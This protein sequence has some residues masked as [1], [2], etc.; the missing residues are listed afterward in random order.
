MKRVLGVVSLLFIFS[1]T[2]FANVDVIGEASIMVVP[3]QVRITVGVD[4]RAKTLPLARQK[5]DKK[6]A[7]I[8]KVLRDNGV[9]REDVQMDHITVNPIYMDYESLILK[10]YT[11]QKNVIFCVKKVD[12][13]E[14]IMSSVLEAGA[15]SVG[16]IQFETTKLDALQIKARKQAILAAKDRAAYLANELGLQIGRAMHIS[17]TSSKQ[18]GSDLL[19]EYAA[20]AKSVTAT[21]SG[22]AFSI[23]QIEVSA[24]VSV[25]FKLLE[26]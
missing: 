8:L 18:S 4:T 9:A 24:Q 6:I 25:Q 13:F 22:S 10:G 7:R 11:V 23:G 26:E 1:H 21:D 15:N 19:R 12:T 2:V 16:G 20:R 14:H 3:D 17:D 5:T